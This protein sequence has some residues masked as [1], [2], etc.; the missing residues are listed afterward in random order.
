M[1]DL[2]LLSLS[3]IFDLQRVIFSV[4]SE[5]IL[6]CSSYP[7][8]PNDFLS[9]KEETTLVVEIISDTILGSTVV[10]SID[11]FISKAVNFEIGFFVKKI[12]P[13]LLYRLKIYK[14]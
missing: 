5:I 2:I 10:P 8:E 4:L 3:D 12:D 9:F 13:A 14:R 11:F 7:E 1:E 6:F